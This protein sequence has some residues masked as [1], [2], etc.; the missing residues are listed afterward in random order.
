MLI[1][2]N[3]LKLSTHTSTVRTE[4][5]TSALKWDLEVEWKTIF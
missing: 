2:F 4:T 3:K 5:E 1:N